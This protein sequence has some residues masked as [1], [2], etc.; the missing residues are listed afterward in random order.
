M[1]LPSPLAPELTALMLVAFAAGSFTQL[2]RQLA[3]PT[4]P[5]LRRTLALSVLGGIAALSVVALLSATLTPAPA[6]ALLLAAACVSGWSGP[7]LLTRLGALIER[8]LGLAPGNDPAELDLP[9][10]ATEKAMPAEKVMPPAPP[11]G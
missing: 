2:A 7:R 11:R 5:T 1:P 3:A 8:R 10:A 6:S 4:S 9:G